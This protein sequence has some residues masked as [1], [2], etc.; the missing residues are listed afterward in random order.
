[1]H[2]LHLLPD[3]LVFPVV[4]APL[5]AAVAAAPYAR[6]FL[7]PRQSR[8]PGHSELMDAFFAVASSV[9][10]VLAFT[11]VSAEST[12]HTIEQQIDRE[13]ATLNDL[14]RTFA[15]YGDPRLTVLRPLAMRYGDS[16]VSDEWPLMAKGGRSTE[17]DAIYDTM[18]DGLRRIEPESHRQQLMYSEALQQIDAL[19]DFR[20]ERIDAGLV[21]LPPIYW[22]ATLFLLGLMVV[23]ASLNEPTPERI[24][25]FAVVATAIGLLVALV[26]VLDAP[27]QGDGSISPEPF[28]RA[29]EQMAARH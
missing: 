15:R 26:V 11:L 25:T 28:Q 14:D 3:Y 7:L 13:A 5:V 21:T 4:I 6:H 29:V 9:A 17:A 18:S 2:W 22:F 12:L 10:L 1:M 24:G 27:F 20:D 8:P 19:S 16:I 23:I